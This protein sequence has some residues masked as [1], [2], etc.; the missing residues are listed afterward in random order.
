MA[1]AEERVDRFVMPLVNV[2]KCHG[3]YKGCHAPR[4]L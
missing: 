1:L 3:P 2:V 4:G